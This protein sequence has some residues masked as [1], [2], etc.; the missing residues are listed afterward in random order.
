ME[1]EGIEE[2]LGS[3]PAG[4]AMGIM[5]WGRGCWGP[6]RRSGW[7]KESCSG[8]ELE[9]R[10]RMASREAADSCSKPFD[11]I[12]GGEMNRLVFW[13]RV[14]ESSDGTPSDCFRS[15]SCWRKCCSVGGR[16]RVSDQDS[17]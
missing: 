11:D 10:A 17:I 2:E 3:C 4:E 5:F 9:L 1:P 7:I 15:S 8:L 16:L 12:G 14:V 13:S 6:A